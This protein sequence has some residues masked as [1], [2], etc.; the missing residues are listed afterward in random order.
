MELIDG[1]MPK[2]C[3]GCSYCCIEMPCF[4]SMTALGTKIGGVCLALFWD[5]DKYRCRAAD[6]HKVSLCIGEGCCSP[7][8]T[9]R[10][11]VKKRA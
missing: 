3:V 4:W 10:Q 7:L 1:V 2:K 9:W 6:T 11:D 8:N 5:E